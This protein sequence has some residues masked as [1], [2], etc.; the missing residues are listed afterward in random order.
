MPI[1]DGRQVSPTVEGIRRDHRERYRLAAS[2]IPDGALALDAACG[3][4][5]G[6]WMLAELARPREVVGVDISPDAIRYAQRHYS[7]P[8]VTFH[9]TD[10]L[11]CRFAAGRFE[12]IVSF[13]TLEHIAEDRAFLAMLERTLAPDGI[14][15]IST[16]NED[17]LHF[18][19]DYYAHHVRH[20]RS[21][22]F[23]QLLRASGFT[24]I[25]A[26]TQPDGELGGI[27]PGFGGAFDI[28]VCAKAGNG[29][30]AGAVSLGHD[31]PGLEAAG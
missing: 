9:C 7:H 2:L 28:A 5:Y 13:E 30:A 23:A 16:P 24:V 21:V 11:A 18:D 26:Y 22:E 19:P 31:T 25:G 3:V 1:E 20:Y 14:L 10:L 6:S 29:S 4:G 8:R 27:R 15:A 17:V 12:V